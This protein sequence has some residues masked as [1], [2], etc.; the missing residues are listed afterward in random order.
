MTP[1]R[2]WGIGL[3]VSLVIAG[4]GDGGSSSGSS[5]PLSKREY[6]QQLVRLYIDAQAVG[7]IYPNL[8]IETASESACRQTLHQYVDLVSSLIERL[9]DLNP[10]AGARDTQAE[11]VDGGRRSVQRWSRL[12]DQVS[13]GELSCGHELG[14]QILRAES[15]SA[16]AAFQRLREL[17]YATFD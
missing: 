16:N 13:A 11:I 9:A 3:C 14:R 5:E 15:D 2:I 12:E 4:C 6:Q 8:E 1:I 17:G 7:D 10:P